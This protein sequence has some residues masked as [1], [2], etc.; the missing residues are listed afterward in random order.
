[1]GTRRVLVVSLLASSLAIGI[2]C[3]SSDPD[4]P[5]LGEA[6]APPRGSA[7]SSSSSSSSSG[8][9]GTV[10]VLPGCASVAEGQCEVFARCVPSLFALFFGDAAVCKERLGMT[11]SI[12]EKS[13][14][15]TPVPAACGPALKALACGSIDD[16]PT[17]CRFQG[18]LANG[19]ACEYD[20]QCQSG[21]CVPGQG[22]PCGTCKPR[23]AE[24]AACASTVAECEYGLRCLGDQCKKALAKGAVCADANGCKSPYRCASGKCRDPLPMDAPCTRAPAGQDD[25]CDVE[26]LL[27]CKT[28]AGVETGTCKRFEFAKPGEACGVG[29][30]YAVYCLGG[31]V[32]EGPVGDQ[33]CVSPVAPGSACNSDG[34]TPCTSPAEC[35]GGKCAYP[36]PARCK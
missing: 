27:Y 5:S 15:A 6:R 28:T 2:A 31:A 22:S 25:P 16:I 12:G 4:P 19:A 17:A 23:A 34:G 35:T 26:K 36:D 3:S 21:S 18:T 1:M 32:C 30:S 29:S 24:N 33:K 10:A 9:S 13:P 7:S 20:A 8:D 14:G 11:C